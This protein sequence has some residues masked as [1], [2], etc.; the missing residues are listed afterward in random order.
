MIMAAEALYWIPR[1][2]WLELT[3]Q[4]SLRQVSL[5]IVIASYN[6]KEQKNSTTKPLMWLS[7][8]EN[9]LDSSSSIV[10][11][12]IINLSLLLLSQY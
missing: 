2:T 6:S 8:I 1:E 7:I 12:V 10:T 9:S 5:F 3:Q 11:I 4:Y